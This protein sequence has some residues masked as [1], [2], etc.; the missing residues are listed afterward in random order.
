MK[1]LQTPEGN[2]RDSIQN[3]S[4]KQYHMV[5]AMGGRGETKRGTED[6]KKHH[7]ELLT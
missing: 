1:I 5:V 6:F 2:E 4:E 3:S 7:S